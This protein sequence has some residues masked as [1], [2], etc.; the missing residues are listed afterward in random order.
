LIGVPQWGQ[1]V[2]LPARSFPHSRHSVEPL[3]KFS[4]NSLALFARRN[5]NKVFRASRSV[6]LPA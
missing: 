1:L 5:H 4:P 3:I 6:R 2:V